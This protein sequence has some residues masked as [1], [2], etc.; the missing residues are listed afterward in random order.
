[1]FSKAI[2]AKLDRILVDLAAILTVLGA[3]KSEGDK[4]M[5]ALD[6]L[7]AQVNASTTV[8]SS[9]IA[10]IQGIAGQIAAAGTNPAALA[11]LTAK[12]NASASAL[13]AA[14][15]ANTPAAPGATAP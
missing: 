11:A 3:L 15:A 10:L 9:A 1:V 6:D 13:A 14:V 7:T 2:H 12:L 8:E 5:A 4:I